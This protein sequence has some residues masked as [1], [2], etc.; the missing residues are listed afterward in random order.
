MVEAFFAGLD[1]EFSSLFSLE[2]FSTG[3]LFK[4][5]LWIEKELSLL[6]LLLTPFKISAGDMSEVA[7]EVSSKGNSSRTS[8]NKFKT[9]C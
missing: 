9:D 2:R 5:S 8:K 1:I 7:A 6:N 3:V 4:G